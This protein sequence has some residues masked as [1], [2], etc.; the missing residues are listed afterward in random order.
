MNILTVMVAAFTT[1][2]DSS[3]LGF[4]SPSLGSTFKNSGSVGHMPLKSFLPEIS[5]DATST[6][7]FFEFTY[8]HRDIENKSWTVDM[9]LDTEVSDRFYVLP[10]KW[11]T[12]TESFHK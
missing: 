9:R 10:M 6:G 3:S 11:Q 12:A 7:L 8:R 1:V 4:S 2:F 5:P